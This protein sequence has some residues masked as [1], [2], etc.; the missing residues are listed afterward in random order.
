MNKL[1]KTNPERW[2]QTLSN[3]I[4]R[5]SQGVRDIK[6]N[7]AL[8]FI[9]YHEIPRS[10]KV[11]YAN[12]ICDHRPL[13]TEKHRVRLIIGGDVLDYAGDAS[14]PAASLIE[15]KLFLNSVISNSDKG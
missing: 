11:A 3:E 9:P 2:G 13:K 1:L 7:N 12:M 4:G 15:A 8:T 6:G 5:L 14:L 10:K